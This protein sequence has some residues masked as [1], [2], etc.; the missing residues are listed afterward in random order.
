MQGPGAFALERLLY[1]FWGLLR[2]SSDDTDDEPFSPT[3]ELSAGIFMQI[4]TLVS[5]QLLTQVLMTQK[6]SVATGLS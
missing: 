4:S 3:D 2:S 5:L 6:A 1:I